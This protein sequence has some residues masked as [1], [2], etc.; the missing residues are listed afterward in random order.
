MR[1]REETVSKR[2]DIALPVGRRKP[3]LLGRLWPRAG[4]PFIEYVLP[5]AV[6]LVLACI[7][8]E[9]WIRIKGTPVYILPAPS[10]VLERLF[11]DIG[12]FARQGWVT[13]YEA[14]L[15]FLLGS[16]IAII[17]AVLMAHSRLLEKS[18][19]PLAVLVKVTPMVAVA[20]LFIIWFGFGVMPKVGVAALITFFPVLVNGITGFRAVNPTVLA[21]L[22][23]L[24]ASRLE[25]LLK[26]RLPSALPYLFAA[27]KVSI[28][29]SLIGAIVGEFFGASKGLGYVISVSHNNLDMPSLFSAI[30]VLAILGS[31]LIIAL[32]ALERRLLF[33]HESLR[34]SRG[35]EN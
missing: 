30:I 32:S 2:R 13:L 29:L 25:V 28:T 11:G 1:M 8:W 14:M 22:Q 33:W 15:G 6:A 26:L 18:L 9:M 24:H 20:P 27:F 10:V 21:F 23:S 35:P 7:G 19:F 5:P 17:G 34:T 4:R 12:Y 31:V 16:A 3:S